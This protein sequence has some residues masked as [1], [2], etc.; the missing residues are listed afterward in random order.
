MYRYVLYTSAVIAVITSIL[1]PFYSYLFN[2]NLVFLLKHL[3]V[4]I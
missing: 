2:L 1:W 3:Y 4:L